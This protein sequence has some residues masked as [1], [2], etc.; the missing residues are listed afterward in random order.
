VPRFW[1]R[2]VKS[3]LPV[4]LLAAG[5]G[6]LYAVGAGAY[7][8]DGRDDGTALREA[9]VWRVPLTMAA[10]AGGLT[11]L[12]EWFRHLWGA[13]Q[14]PKAAAEAKASVLDSE[15]LLLQLLEQAE[16]AEKSRGSERIPILGVDTDTP[17]P[18]SVPGG[19]PARTV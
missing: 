16:A 11:L 10:W 14:A 6:Y 19:Q 4:A 3:V 17:A 13:K 8:A 15:Q 18:G 2:L 12:V 5:A 7:V 9:L 1:P